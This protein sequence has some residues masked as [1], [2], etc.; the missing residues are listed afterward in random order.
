MYYIYCYKNKLN[1]HKYIG[2]TNNIKRRT[3]EHKSAAFNENSKDYYNLFHSKLRQYGEENFEFVILEEIDTENQQLVD[4]REKYW[5]EFEN[6]YVRNGNGYN[7]TTG[8]QNKKS[9]EKKMTREQAKE[10]QQKLIKGVPYEDISKEYSIIPSYISMINQGNYFHDKTLVYPLHKF[11]KKDEEYQELVA[12]LKYSDLTLKAIAEK[13]NIGYSTVKKIN[14]GTLRHG[15]SKIYP[16]R[17]KSVYAIKADRVKD[18]L[19]NTSLTTREIMYEVDVS[20]ETIRR[21]NNGESHYD[22]NL[23][24]P[25]R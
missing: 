3:R 15:L 22:S 11:Y 4:E 23:T 19:L 10:I 5:I 14:A 9:Q 17:N 12:L 6:S 2:Q 24:Y 8:G 25:L 16:I 20:D 1:G 21:I 13:L 18:L 7:I